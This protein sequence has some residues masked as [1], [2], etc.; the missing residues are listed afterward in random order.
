MSESSVLKLVC[1]VIIFISAPING[2]LLSI[3]KKSGI[4]L[5]VDLQKEKRFFCLYVE[6]KMVK[7]KRSLF[8]IKMG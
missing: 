8:D 5:Q 4:F 1:L 2:N 6:N 7:Q 3:Y